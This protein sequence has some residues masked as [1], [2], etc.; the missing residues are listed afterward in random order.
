MPPTAPPTVPQLLAPKRRAPYEVAT[1]SA[2]KAIAANMKRTTRI[3]TPTVR[4]SV[5]MGRRG[6]TGI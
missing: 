1:K 3:A 5:M 4:K 2:R 6:L